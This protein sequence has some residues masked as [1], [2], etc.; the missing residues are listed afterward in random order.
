MG[1]DRRPWHG[2]LVLR[3]NELTAIGKLFYKKSKFRSNA[4][5]QGSTRK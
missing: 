2:L 1:I 5:K 3:I 4:I